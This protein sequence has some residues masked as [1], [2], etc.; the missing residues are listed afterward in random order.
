MHLTSFKLLIPLAIGKALSAPLTAD[1]PPD[2]SS[3][4]LGFSDLTQTPFHSTSPF[5][6]PLHQNQLFEVNGKY[7]FCGCIPCE[8]YCFGCMG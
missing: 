4:S 7:C 6:H 5:E 2:L 8:E 3:P 1:S